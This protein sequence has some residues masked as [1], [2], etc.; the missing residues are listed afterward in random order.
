VLLKFKKLE[1]LESN[2]YLTKQKGRTNFL[3]DGIRLRK[4]T[5]MESKIFMLSIRMLCFQKYGLTLPVL[6]IFQIP[7]KEPK[8]KKFS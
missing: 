5:T 7:I 8:T 2:E 3:F 1:N 6:E 4:I